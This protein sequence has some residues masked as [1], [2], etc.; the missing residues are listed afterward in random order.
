[1]ADDSISELT[2]ERVRALLSYDPKTGIFR[3]LV[4]NSPRAQ[5]GSVA[6]YEDDRGYIWIGIDG[7]VYLAHRVAWLWIKGVMPVEIDHRDTIK[8]N[9]RWRNL[10][11]ATR[12]QN[13]V[14]AGAK[15]D[16]M[17]KHRGVTF[18]KGHKL[19]PYHAYCYFNGK[20]HSFG[21][22]ATLEDAD[23]ARLAGAK[24]LYGEFARG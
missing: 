24:A 21:Y 10:R 16:S 18:I 23:A 12:A 17:T 19:R 15:A 20:K 13:I 8:S 22:H 6:G 9:N 14:N 2:Q 4:T 7:V 11:D 5:A 1:M 3:W